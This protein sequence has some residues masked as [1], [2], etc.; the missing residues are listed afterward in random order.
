MKIK[1]LEQQEKIRKAILNAKARI[2][3]MILAN[4]SMLVYDLQ[5]EYY[6]D[7]E[8]NL[9]INLETILDYDYQEQVI[10]FLKKQKLY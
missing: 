3:Q 1:D 9:K 4:Q 2:D 8:Y 6:E 7:F 5:K 10:D